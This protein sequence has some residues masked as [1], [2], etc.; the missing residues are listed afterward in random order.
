MA[1]AQR[2]SMRGNRDLHSSSYRP[3]QPHAPSQNSKP[4]PS[5]DWSTNEPVSPKRGNPSSFRFGRGKDPQPFA[6]AAINPRPAT[7]SLPHRGALSSSA[8]G[9][10]GSLCS[11]ACDGST[12]EP[13]R[14]PAAAGLGLP[15]TRPAKVRGN[16]AQ[17]E[18]R[19]CHLLPPSVVDDDCD[20]SQDAGEFSAL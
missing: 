2:A 15:A 13:K 8:C 1:R 12:A 19:M 6:R 17:D 4:V 9:T 7:N 11:I 18:P 3:R 20:P 10:I 14:E 16:A 5:R